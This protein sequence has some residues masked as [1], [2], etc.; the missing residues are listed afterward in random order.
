MYILSHVVFDESFFPYVT[1]N[2]VITPGHSPSVC[3]PMLSV[4]APCNTS[5]SSNTLP[6]KTPLTQPYPSTRIKS[7]TTNHSPH[8]MITRN[9][10]KVTKPPANL[11]TKYALSYSSLPIE[12]TC[13]TQANKDKK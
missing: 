10:G 3:S 9:K 1:S 7:T 11:S 4:I 8:H 5:T 2:R 6:L 12:P 13:F